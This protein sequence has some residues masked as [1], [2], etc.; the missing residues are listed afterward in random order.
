MFKYVHSIV[1]CGPYRHFPSSGLNTLFI[2][3]DSV[4]F[5]LQSDHTNLSYQGG[6]Q[7]EYNNQ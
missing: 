3:L 5:Y 4:A 6:C 7:K 2:R 1:T